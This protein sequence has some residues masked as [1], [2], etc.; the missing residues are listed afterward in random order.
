MLLGL[1][2][3]SGCGRRGPPQPPLRILPAPPILEPILQEG[4]ALVVRWTA[5]LGDAEGFLQ[6][7]I[8]LRRA[9]IEMRVVDVREM[10]ADL[11]A[12]NRSG[13]T[14]TE[15]EAVEGEAGGEDA[16][17]EAVEGEAGGEDVADEAVEGEATEEEVAPDAPE[18]GAP[19][20]G[21]PQPPIAGPEEPAPDAAEAD[22]VASEGES[23]DGETAP[24]A[25][26]SGA[27][28]SGDPQPPIAG[29][30]E[31][32][33]DAAEADAVAS[34]GES[35]DG[36]TAPDAPESG[37]PDSGDPQPPIAAPEEPVPDAAEADAAA[38]EG[39]GADGETAPDA[40][41]SGAPD[42]GDPQPPIAAPE[43]P[44]PDAAEADAAASEGEGADGETAPDAPESGA[45]DSGDPQPPIAAPEAPVPDAAEADAAASEGEGADGET[46]PDAPESGAPDSGD[47]QPPIAAPEAPVPDAAEADAAASEGEAETV[48]PE[49]EGADP[50]AVAPEA[51]AEPAGPLVRY[52][53]VEFE[54]FE[55]I[56]SETPGETHTLR[57]PIPDEWKGKRLEFRVHYES[58]S[59]A[60]QPAEPLSTDITGV[61]PTV[62]GVDP[63]VGDGVVTVVWDD[64]R[65]A[66]PV[67]E[68]ADLSQPMFEV[69]R[70][71]GEEPAERIGRALGPEYEDRD[72]QWEVEACYSVRL[73]VAAET[74]E[75]VIEDPG[76]EFDP[77]PEASEPDSGGETPADEPPDSPDAPAEPTSEASADP[78]AA[79][80]PE[81][82]DPEAAAVPEP[83]DPEAAAVP[84]P[85]DPEAAAVP[86]PADPEAAAVSEPVD[87]DAAAPE[88]DA[89]AEADWIPVPVRVPPASAGALSVG[90]MSE[91]VCVTPLDVF[92]PAVPAGLRAFQGEAASEL[93]WL[94]VL[95]DDLAGYHVYRAGEI[96]TFGRLTDAPIQQAEFQDAD[97][98]PESVYRYQVTSVDAAQPANESA[99]SEPVVVRPR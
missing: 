72:V 82:A 64:A 91:S 17:D 81:P 15:E 94:P 51:E 61:L 6:E 10:A 32:A 54:P 1:L 57:V 80:V 47:P 27:P 7:D 53:D 23:A 41:E 98:D 3:A 60:G 44:V 19:D 50:D 73:V 76:P 65:D 95:A 28:D 86:E 87:P 55:E 37:A 9:V 67:V 69:F 75:R 42:S 66:E 46:A 14:A 29:P 93:S 2:A 52:E 21:D 68:A 74:E 11:R 34:E 88:A 59:G 12:G 97:R 38:S 92:P 24:D 99:P 30:E 25:P 35:A 13:A 83:V 56:E 31:P 43:A 5:P 26:E 70:Q 45:P 78:E 90:P 33:P 49:G 18:S 8:R 79:A 96:G 85:V 63:E 22:A 62:E 4:D 84:E 77:L 20:S 89:P 36:E 40:P 39:E 16:A 71:R 48:A 58:A